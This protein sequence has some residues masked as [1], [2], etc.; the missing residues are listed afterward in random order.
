MKLFRISIITCSNYAE[1][2][3]GLLSAG[4]LLDH[5]IR[6]FSQEP[7]FRDYV[8]DEAV[9]IKWNIGL[10]EIKASLWENY[11]L[12]NNL[13]YSVVPDNSQNQIW[14]QP[15]SLSDGDL[16][17]IYKHKKALRSFLFSDDEFC[18]V[19]EDDAIIQPGFLV[20]IESICNHIMFDY[21][22]FA[23]G[24]NLNCNPENIKC[25]SGFEL[26]LK[27]LKSTRTACGYI[28]SRR[29]AWA[30]LRELESPYMPIDWSISVALTKVSADCRVYWLNTCIALHGSSV[31]L[32]RSWRA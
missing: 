25:V 18:V 28:C 2:L 10:T 7:P 21:M 8:Y 14:M 3:I 29:A 6:I 24:D 12:A 30:I 15:R 26:E 20:S 16:S 9:I 13:D 19:L 1:R 11:L 27:S 22:D 17:V 32:Y 23:G 4:D 5:D 31:G